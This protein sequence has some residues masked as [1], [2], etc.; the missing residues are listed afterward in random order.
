MS[1]QSQFKRITRAL[2]PNAGNPTAHM[3]RFLQGTKALLTRH[4]TVTAMVILTCLAWLICGTRVLHGD[5][6]MDDWALRANAHFTGFTGTFH[7]L[8]QQD[9]RRPVGALYFAT[10][11]ALVG[12]HVRALLAIST[13]MHLLLAGALYSLL[14]ELRFVWFDALMIAILALLFPNADSTWMWPSASSASLAIT[15]VLIGCALNLHAMRDRGQRGAA[16]RVAGLLLISAGIL[17]YELVAAIGLASGALYF[18]CVPRRHAL[19]RWSID[20]AVLIGVLFLFTFR[21][22]PVFHGGDN[23]EVATFMQMHEHAHVIVTQSARLLTLSLLPFGTPRN[24]TVL[25]L[26]AALLILAIVVAFILSHHDDARRQ[27]VTW[28][29]VTGVGVLTIGLGY[30]GFVPSNIYYVPLQPGLGNRVNCVA[31]I[32]YALIV[33][34]SARLVGTLT[35]RGLP[36]SRHLIS[37]LAVGVGVVIS[38]GYVRQ[39]HHDTVAWNQA[40]ILSR[41]VLQMLD[42]H[43]PTPA[44]NTSIVTIDAPVETAPGVPV[45]DASWDLNGAVQLLWNDPNLRAYPMAPGMNITCTSTGLDV[46]VANGQPSWQTPYPTN[47]VNVS[48]GRVFFVSK[49]TRCAIAATKLGLPESS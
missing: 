39:I 26:F 20:A 18:A 9:A 5:F 10:I 2:G 8:L 17:T 25:G 40:G 23:H 32:G 1:S 24:S 13:I 46:N 11:F 22:V 19:R 31:A 14:R 47:L 44:P 49:E 33:Y 37:L 41:T 38:L 4:P 21:I 7:I 30:I 43:L 27:L 48:T 16:F 3:S 45:F 35:F 15:F 6:I 12:H 36:Y 28:L 34:G 29:T 42:K